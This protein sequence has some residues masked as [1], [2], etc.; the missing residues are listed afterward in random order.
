MEFDAPTILRIFAF[1][2]WIGGM[3][4]FVLVVVKQRRL[5]RVKRLLKLKRW[6][7]TLSISQ[8][9]LGVLPL[10]ARFYI[11]TSHTTDELFTA[12]A[13]FCAA[14]SYFLTGLALYA[15]YTQNPDPD[16]E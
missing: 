3:V 15:I 13:S 14:M 8:T 4:Q 12:T 6:L 9:A 2:A 16:K 7:I 10:M 1:I 5:M 11:L